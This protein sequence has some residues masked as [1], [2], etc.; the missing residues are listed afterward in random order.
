MASAEKGVRRC[1]G[2]LEGSRRAVL[3]RC[4]RVQSRSCRTGATEALASN[5]VLGIAAVARGLWQ[6][7][8]L[9][10][11]ASL[12]A[13]AVAGVFSTALPRLM[14]SALP[15]GSNTGTPASTNSLT[16]RLTT[17]MS[18]SA[19]I[20]AIKKIRLTEG[21]ATPL[22]LNNHGFP[23]DDHICRNGENASGK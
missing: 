17:T 20:A 13:S 16:S 23:S 22:A 5:C 6:V 18:C 2:G 10:K 9:F 11:R 21:V 3:E 19:A 4:D 12:A 1:D 8:Q 14:C 15:Q 7:S